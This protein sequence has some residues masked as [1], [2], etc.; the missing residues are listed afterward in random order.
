M[1]RM[2]IWVSLI[3]A[4]MAVPFIATNSVKAQ[5]EVT[6]TINLITCH[7]PGSASSIRIAE[8][9]DD[10]ICE[11]TEPYW[12]WD[13]EPEFFLNGV[14]PDGGDNYSTVVFTGLI[15]G[16]VYTITQ[17]NES[18]ATWPDQEYTFTAPDSDFELIAI[19]AKHFNPDTDPGEDDGE[20]GEVDED[21]VTG[22]P[23]TG[24]GDIGTDS[25]SP[26]LPLVAI[27]IAA[28][29]GGFGLRRGYPLR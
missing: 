2:Q 22:L 1:N 11:G 9:F 15:P 27:M 5:N 8:S 21:E 26:L 28:L 13:T 4:L 24:V 29:V 23:N 6:L 16:A 20:S 17:T 3:V 25:G 14:S 10:S 7:L 12:N 18:V 19:Y